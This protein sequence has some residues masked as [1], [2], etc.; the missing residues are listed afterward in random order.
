MGS[1]LQILVVVTI[2]V[3]LLCFGYSLFAGQLAAIRLAGLNGHGQKRRSSKSGRPG[4]PQVCPVCSALLNRGELVS[5]HAFPSLTGGKDRLMH[6]RGCLY[7]LGGYS[8]R[9][10]PICGASLQN[11]EYLIARLFER[12]HH[13]HNHVHVLGCSRCRVA[14]RFNV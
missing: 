3:I 14:K 12:P 10:C 6:I 13:R 8:R 5:S 7:C 1:L 2:G 11:N 4:D 9:R